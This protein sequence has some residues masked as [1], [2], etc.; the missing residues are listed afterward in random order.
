MAALFAARRRDGLRSDMNLT[1]YSSPGSGNVYK[2]ELMLKLLRLPYQIRPVDLRRNEQYNA[3]FMARTRFGQVPVLVDGD[4][5]L[6]DSHAIL[7]YLAGTYGNPAVHDWAPLEPLKLA[8]VMRWLSVS[9]NEIQNGLAVARAVK[10][11]N[12]PYDYDQAVRMAYRILGIMDQHLKG[13]RWLA[14]DHATVADLACYPYVLMAGEGGVDTRPYKVVTAWLKR[15]E[16][17]PGFWPM[18][19]LQNL[20]E[21]PLV[22]APVA[23]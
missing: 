14:L 8:R 22:P 12:W 3:D 20:P 11:L 19:R 17:L 6:T 16:S 21:V 2:V 5:V 15:V 1:L 4:L 23:G 10:L 18:P 13:R 9:A 7:I